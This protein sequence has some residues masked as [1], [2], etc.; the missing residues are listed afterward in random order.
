MRYLILSVDY[1]IFGNGSGDVRQHV[2][3]PTD[4]LA[5]ICE[6]Q[7]VPLT[8]FFEVE[9]YLAFMRHAGQLKRDLG[10][11][12]AAL[13]AKQIISLIGKGHDVQLHLHPE[14][15]GACYQ[16]GQWL[17][18]P[19]KKNVDSLFD[20]QS[21]VDAYIES[22][23]GVIE[24]LAAKAGSSQKVN[25][26]RA[27]AFSAQPGRKLLAA[28]A[29]NGFC[30][31]SSVVRGLFSADRGYDYRLA[32]DAKGP[33]R[34]R[35][36]VARE[37][38]EGPLWEFPIYSVMGR[39]F[40]QLT[41]R[42]L[43]AKFSKNIPKVKQKEMVAQ[44]NLNPSNPFKILRF[45]WQPVPIKLDFH[46]MNARKMLRWIDIA[47]K[48]ENGQCDALVFIGHT[49]EHIDDRPLEQLL[50]KLA[51][52]PEVKVISFWDLAHQMRT[53]WNDEVRKTVPKS[54]VLG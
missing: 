25:V 41:F 10:Y 54:P 11:D 20:S 32:P 2:I 31:D 33:W 47:P 3:E 52:N 15:H 24:D 1:E 48:P 37:E 35:E 45:L 38:A 44:L 4:R 49:K 18:N 17:L 6:K 14:W 28:L 34:V 46:N 40:N 53:G 9:E 30:I 7:N 16:E 42:T 43:R 29:N 26:Y 22:R 12:P 21:E 19:T 5:R 13:I 39:R 51:D 23:K 50:S 36:D 27:G 8:V